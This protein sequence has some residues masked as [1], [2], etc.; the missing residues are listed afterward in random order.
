MPGIWSASIFPSRNKRAGDSVGA[1]TLFEL[2]SGCRL[3]FGLM[4]LKE[5]SPY[6]YAGLGVMLDQPQLR[7]RFRQ[8][9]SHPTNSGQT[10]NFLTFSN[11]LPNLPK[12]SEAEFHARIDAWFRATRGNDVSP[13]KTS[14]EIVQAFAFHCGLGTG[15]QLACLLTV[16]AEWLEF[17]LNRS[18]IPKL[19]IAKDNMVGDGC[20]VWQL[21]PNLDATG[22]AIRSRRGQRSGIGVHGFLRGGLVLDSG[23]LAPHENG[24]T[25]RT[26]SYSM[27]QDW[28]VVL[29]QTSASSQI[30][31]PLEQEL[32]R[33]VSH[34]SNPNREL[35]WQ[36]AETC[37]QCAHRSDFDSFVENL[38]HY[39]ELAS[40]L[41]APVQGGRFNGS[42][43]RSAA[44]AAIEVGLRA[45]GQSS[46]GPTVF[47]LA[48]D[49]ETARQAA[50][51]ILGDHPHWG[52][53][54]ASGLNS[55]AQLCR[56]DSPPVD[57]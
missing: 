16:A 44:A 5:G 33:K 14:V 32:M 34:R 51:A 47:G 8:A 27:P 46:W 26:C 30:T 29:I 55:G 35:M 18:S 50:E 41:F 3:H 36:L 57:A 12:S 39:L 49:A 2:R 21:W 6:C 15:T 23:L 31:G 13:A 9:T 53:N 48:P 22:L 56:I 1:E 52:V 45:V 10:D 7:L 43:C 4:E 42:Q 40:Q 37:C 17:G 11:T 28:K 38:E 54:I 24:S 25:S 19:D 20:P